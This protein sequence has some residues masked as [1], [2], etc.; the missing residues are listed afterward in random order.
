MTGTLP[1][2]GVAISGASEHRTPQERAA[3]GKAARAVAPR[4]GQGE[5]ESARG[6]QDPVELLQQQSAVRVP[7][8]VPIRYGRMTE[9]PFRFYRGAAGIMAA[10]LATTADSGIRAQLCGDAHLLNFRL[11]ASPERRLMFDIN[12]FDEGWERARGIDGRTRDFYLR[13][14]RDWKGVIEPGVMLP[15]GLGMFGQLCGATLA[16]AHARSGDRVGIAAYL[17]SGDAFDKALARFAESYADQNE[18]DHQAL[19]QAVKTGRVA[20]RTA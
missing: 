5:Y 10:D 13:Q 11:L 8:L 14:L 17:G 20:A 18:R 6:R 3:A 9:S 2:T 16:R 7:E 12:D 4:A 19:V 15:E 1:M